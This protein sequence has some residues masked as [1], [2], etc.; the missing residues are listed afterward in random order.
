MIEGN[1]TKKEINFPAEVIFKSIFRNRPYT[2]E[3]IKTILAEHSID[4]GNVIAKE[5][6]GGKFISYTVTGIFPSE[7]NLN[8]VCTQITM[9]EG[10]MSLF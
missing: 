4:Q 5:S 9:I 1:T 3:S 6:S 2:M 8:T 7:E 10:F